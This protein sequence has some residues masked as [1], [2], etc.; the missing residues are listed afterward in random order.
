MRAPFA[1]AEAEELRGLIAAAGFRD[2]TIRPVPGTVRFPSVARFVQDYVAGS[3]L[4]GHVAKVSDEARAALVSEVGDAL[5]SHLRQVR[6]RFR[7]KPTWRARRSER[8]CHLPPARSACPPNNGLGADRL[9]QPLS[10]SVLTKDHVRAIR[11]G[12]PSRSSACEPRAVDPSSH[13]SPG[14]DPMLKQPISAR[15]SPQQLGEAD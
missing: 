12:C 1:L 6:W 13:E 10:L 9:R 8:A 11:H 15:P 14:R 7:L 4:A 5:R 3:P 2:I